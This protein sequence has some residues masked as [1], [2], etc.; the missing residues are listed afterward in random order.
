MK[1]SSFGAIVHDGRNIM[2]VSADN[3]GDQAQLRGSTSARGA[4]FPQR[5]YATGKKA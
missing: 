3:A 2:N 4:P 1:G 5:Y